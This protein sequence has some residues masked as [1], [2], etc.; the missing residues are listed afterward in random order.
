MVGMVGK[1][2]WDLSEI[3]D[4]ED[5][6]CWKLVEKIVEKLHGVGEK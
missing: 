6:R 4:V 1:F 5:L 2:I 3:H